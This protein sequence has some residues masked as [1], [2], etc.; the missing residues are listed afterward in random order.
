MSNLVETLSKFD[1]LSKK[2][3]SQFLGLTQQKKLKKGS[4]LIKAGETCT[5]LAFLESGTMRSYYL[6]DEKDITVSFSL[7]G[8]FITSMSSFIQQKPSYEYITALEDCAL[9]SINYQNLMNLLRQEKE[10][11]EAYRQILES[12]YVQLEEQL[13]FSKFKSAKERYVELIEK[14]PQIIQKAAIGQIA[15]YLDMSIETLSRIRSGI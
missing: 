5:C 4:F 8:D 1:F 3:I 9:K 14:Q 7:D 12:Y 15:S 2:N 11:S 13:I 6:K 10:L